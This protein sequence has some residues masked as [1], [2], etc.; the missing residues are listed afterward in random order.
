MFALHIC[1]LNCF[2]LN[3]LYAV[4][5]PFLPQFYEYFHFFFAPGNLSCSDDTSIFLS[6]CR[7]PLYC[8]S[9]FFYI[10]CIP[11]HSFSSLLY[12]ALLN[13]FFLCH[14]N[15]LFFYSSHSFFSFLLSPPFL[16]ILSYPLSSFLPPLF[17]SFLF[18]A[19]DA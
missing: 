7:H 19:L 5:N 4:F 17:S 1:I 6:L 9:Y 11:F 13:S 10:S 3:S 8:S 12:S 15:L 18:Q 14:S 2:G 16:L